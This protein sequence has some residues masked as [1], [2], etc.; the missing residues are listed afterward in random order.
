MD[1]YFSCWLSTENGLIW[2]FVGPA[3]LITLVC[4][5]LVSHKVCYICHFYVKSHNWEHT[6]NPL[7]YDKILDLTKLKVY[8]DDK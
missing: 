7:P 8:A 5:F 3:L 6:L 2:A 4:I 1:F